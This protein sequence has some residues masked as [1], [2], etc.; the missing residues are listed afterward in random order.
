MK[1]NMIVSIDAQQA[2][3]KI[4]HSCRINALNKLG[5]EENFLILIRGIQG[6]PRADITFNGEILNAFPL[7]TDTG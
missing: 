2:F 5:I 3:D 4:Q 7:K 6:K 1:N